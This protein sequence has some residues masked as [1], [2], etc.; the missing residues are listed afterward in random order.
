MKRVWIIGCLSLLVLLYAGDR[1]W[2]GLAAEVTRIAADAKAP[3]QMSTVECQRFAMAF[4][5][6]IGR[7]W[8][9]HALVF[10]GF[11]IAGAIAH[12]AAQTR[13]SRG[14][15]TIFVFF[16]MLLGTAVF[17]ATEQLSGVLT[18]EQRMATFQGA[19]QVKIGSVIVALFAGRTFF[20][21]F[22][23]CLK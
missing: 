16:V 19:L 21:M 15:I 4:I 12:G 6:I 10:S 14:I 2:T 22:K 13:V 11:S 23:G 9:L 5:D 3:G 17:L 18:T 8:Y 20:E 7:D 1:M